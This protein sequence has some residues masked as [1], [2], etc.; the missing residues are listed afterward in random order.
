[1][2]N[3][4]DSE[5]VKGLSLRRLAAVVTILILA[6]VA[7]IP[8]RANYASL[9]M[10]ASTGRVLYEA[11]ADLPRYP[12]SLTKMMTLYMLFEALDQGRLTLDDTLYTSSHAAAQSPTKLGLH[13]GQRIRVE[14]AILGLCTK[15]A[16]DAAA[17]IAEAVGGSEERFAWQM[18]TRAHQLGMTQSTFANA[19]GL[20]D[21]N[22][23]TT[24]RDMAILAL[25]LL[26]DYPHH[27][28]YF[29]TE[30]FWWGGSAHA[31]HNRLLG[32]YAGVDG[33]KTGYTHASGFN[34][35]ASAQ[36]DGRRL[37]GVVMGARSPGNRSVIMSSLLDQG[38][39][40][41]PIYMAQAAE[42]PATPA[43]PTPSRWA[44]LTP[45]APAI[46]AADA[47][48]VRTTRSLR[49]ERTKRQTV[50]TARAARSET[51]AVAS[52]SVASRSG[53]S[54]TVAS[55]AERKAS[56]LAARSMQGR[57]VAAKGRA[58]APAV[59]AVTGSSSKNRPAQRVGAAD[60]KPVVL[61]ARSERRGDSA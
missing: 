49:A 13:P 6:L 36:R 33:I 23:V 42:P 59:V 2:R 19:S 41:G 10:D 34:L 56:T 35:V 7:S 16:N 15:S 20:P 26:H 48:P 60:R 31:N 4:A 8:A 24:A 40:G 37:I 27:Y 46:D 5:A 52:R 9:V 43:A 32:T 47:V 57:S 51:R 30:R 18:T 39:E 21:P 28:H 55:P 54:R 3:A 12:A 53:K 58:R 29:G 25:A 1:M 50:R 17:V 22:Q 38:F 44:A 45:P 14:D 61:A 11:N